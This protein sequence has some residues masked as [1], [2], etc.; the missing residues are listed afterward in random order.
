MGQA[1][2]RLGH[3]GRGMMGQASIDRGHDG[4]GIDSARDGFAVS[5]FVS[6]WLILRFGGLFQNA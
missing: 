1:S 5:D 2:T 3:D 4:T 6:C